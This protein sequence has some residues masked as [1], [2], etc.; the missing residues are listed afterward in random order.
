MHTNRAIFPTFSLPSLGE[1]I[2]RHQLFWKP[3]EPVQTIHSQGRG[4]FLNGGG[5]EILGKNFFDTSHFKSHQ[6]EKEL[7]GKGFW[8]GIFPAQKTKHSTCKCPWQEL[9]W[10]WTFPWIPNVNSL[11]GRGVWTGTDLFMNF[12]LRFPWSLL[13]LGP[14][15]YIHTHT[16]THTHVRARTGVR[17]DWPVRVKKLFQMC[18]WGEAVSVCACWVCLPHALFTNTGIVDSTV[19]FLTKK[20]NRR[21]RTSNLHLSLEWFDHF[22]LLVTLTCALQQAIKCCKE[23]IQILTS[24]SDWIISLPPLITYTVMSQRHPQVRMQT[25]VAHSTH[26]RTFLHQ[27][28]FCLRSKYLS[29]PDGCRILWWGFW[30]PILKKNCASVSYICLRCLSEIVWGSEALSRDRLRIKSGHDT[31]WCVRKRFS[32]CIWFNDSKLLW[33]VLLADCL[34]WSRNCSFIAGKPMVFFLSC[35][36]FWVTVFSLCLQNVLQHVLFFS[37]TVVTKGGN[38]PDMLEFGCDLVFRIYLAQKKYSPLRDK[39]WCPF[40]QLFWFVSFKKRYQGGAGPVRLL[41][42]RKFLCAWPKIQF[43]YFCFSFD[44]IYFCCRSGALKT[45]VAQRKAPSLLKSKVFHFKSWPV[46]FEMPQNNIWENNNKGDWIKSLHCMEIQNAFQPMCLINCRLVLHGVY[47][48]FDKAYRHERQPKSS[49]HWSSANKDIAHVKRA[50]VMFMIRVIWS[51]VAGRFHRWTS[52]TMSENWGS[53]K[54]T[55]LD[56]QS[57]FEVRTNDVYS[58]DADYLSRFCVDFVP[59]LDRNCIRTI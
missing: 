47:F 53:I 16:H 15:T 38:G 39:R 30:N 36:D 29:C 26:A 45:G 46:L 22:A 42:L 49:R 51:P 2:P 5:W 41:I 12:S 24:S 9:S 13:K 19:K 1:G 59:Y 32:F 8:T 33:V 7:D 17:A 48:L 44:H 11:R 50:C 37:D 58:T 21:F 20:G 25:G 56:T 54:Y 14:H 57:D 4:W 35:V 28:D 3:Q 55:P 6:R 10:T 18:S 27:N 34:L 40:E 43:F 31:H 23:I 52:N